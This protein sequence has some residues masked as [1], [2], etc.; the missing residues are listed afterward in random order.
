V[1]R[2]APA[3]DPQLLT[4]QGGFRRGCS[5]AQQVA[6]LTSDVVESYEGRR[7]AGLVLMALTTACDAVWHHGLALKLL[8][9]VR[10]GCVRT[11]SVWA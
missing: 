2:L 11:L 5:T 8:K 3:F 1:I 10:H 4:Q 9:G 7:K 6:K